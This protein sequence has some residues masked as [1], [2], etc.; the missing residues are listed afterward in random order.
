MPKD[1]QLYEKEMALKN[2]RLSLLKADYFIVFTLLRQQSWHNCS[3]K[4]LEKMKLI[5][6]F[7]IFFK[8][9]L[10]G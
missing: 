7:L 5:P 9:W 1:T 3:E 6:E 10:S 2:K 8:N 4:K